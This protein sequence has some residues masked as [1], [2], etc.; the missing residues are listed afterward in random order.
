MLIEAARGLNKAIMVQNR[1]KSIDGHACGNGLLIEGV[2]LIDDGEESL[3]IL[4]KGGEALGYFKVEDILKI[5][6]E[7]RDEFNASTK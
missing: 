5:A 3:V 6:R 1:Y 2:I 4:S 7:G